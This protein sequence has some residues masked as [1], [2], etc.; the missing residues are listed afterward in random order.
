V[1]GKNR[2]WK[3]VDSKKRNGF[4][5]SPN[6]IMVMESRMVRWAEVCASTKIHRN[7]DRRSREDPLA[8]HSS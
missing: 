8:R 5:F 2:R 1:E 7:F 6:I 4:Y 3:A